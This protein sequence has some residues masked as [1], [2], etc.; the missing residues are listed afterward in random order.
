MC[1]FGRRMDVDVRH[2]AKQLV[3]GF[4]ILWMLIKRSPFQAF[5]G[6]NR[7]LSFSVQKQ[8][9]IFEKA[10]HFSFSLTFSHAN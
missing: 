10:L 8:R 4:R 9:E 6:P 2:L 1:T 5:Y 3:K 7:H